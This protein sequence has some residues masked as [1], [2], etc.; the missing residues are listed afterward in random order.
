MQNQTALM[1]MSDYHQSSQIEAVVY[2]DDRK[3]VDEI[4]KELN[5]EIKSVAAEITRELNGVKRKQSI[6]PNSEKTVILQDMSTLLESKTRIVNEMTK[7]IRESK[8]NGKN[9]FH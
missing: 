1:T 6:A 5:E 9:E 3:G 2:P 4:V 7:H 8:F